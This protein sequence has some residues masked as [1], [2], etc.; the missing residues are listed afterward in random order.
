MNWK[1]GEPRH[2]LAHVQDPD[3][4]PISSSQSSFCDSHQAVIRSGVEIAAAG[5]QRRNVLGGQSHQGVAPALRYPVKDQE[6]P[7]ET[8]GVDLP[9]AHGHGVRIHYKA[10]FEVGKRMP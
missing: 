1:I 4:L 2:V 10:V 9:A 7:I 8:A 3:A 5:S 6:A